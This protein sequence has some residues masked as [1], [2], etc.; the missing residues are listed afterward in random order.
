MNNVL[1]DLLLC[2]TDSSLTEEETRNLTEALEASPEA[3]R[4]RSELIQLK[5]LA[6]VERAESF[7]PFFTER[8]MA[9]LMH[10]QESLVDRFILVFRPIA[11]SALL[12]TVLLSSYNVL[13]GDSFSLFSPLGIHQ[14]TLEQ[15]LTLE[16]PFE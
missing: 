5:K 2:S 9:R 6:Q 1:Y 3:R 4:I 14:H 13:R 11:Y 10:R 12:L 15:K 8:V 7:S 16:I